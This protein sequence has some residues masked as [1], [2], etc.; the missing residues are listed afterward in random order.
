MSL[1]VRIERLIDTTP[2]LAF[3]HWVDAEARRR[4][5]A[6][7]EGFIVEA[8]TDLRVGGAW[9]VAFGKTA[10]EMYTEEGVFSVVDPPRR[11]VYNCV[12]TFPDGRAFETHVTVTFEERDGKTLMTVLDADY[13]S[14]EQRQ[15]HENG[16]P[17]F[18]DAYER[19]LAG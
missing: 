7:E 15:A 3:H 1:D 2:E 13:P 9:R 19:T 8:S 5:Y 14:E 18:I 11:L 10:D 6:P 16:W 4:W 12:F 17:A